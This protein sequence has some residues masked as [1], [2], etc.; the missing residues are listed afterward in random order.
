MDMLVE[1][2]LRREAIKLYGLDGKKDLEIKFQDMTLSITYDKNVSEETKEEAS[3]DTEESIIK[4]IEAENEKV[5]EEV[6]SKPKKKVGRPR[7]KRK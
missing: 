1:E 4:E 3:V 6:K 2:L 5:K 7:K